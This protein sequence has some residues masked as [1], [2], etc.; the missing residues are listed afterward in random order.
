MLHLSQ[1]LNS[2]EEVIRKDIHKTSTFLPNDL[3]WKNVVIG[4][5]VVAIHA[6]LCKYIYI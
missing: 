6:A 1:P 5:T 4:A 2:L 3:K